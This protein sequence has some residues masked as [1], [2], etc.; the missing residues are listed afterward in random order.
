LKAIKNEL[1]ARGDSEFVENPKQIVAN[2]SG[3]TTLGFA[4]AFLSLDFYRTNGAQPNFRA[5]PIVVAAL[6]I[7]DAAL[8]VLRRLRNRASPLYGD[9][10]HFYDLLLARAWQPRRLILASVSV[11]AALGVVANAALAVREPLGVVIEILCLAAL[12]TAA[13][14]LGSLRADDAASSSCRDALRDLE[15]AA[16]RPH[17]H[18]FAHHAA[19]QAEP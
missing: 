18:N 19:R 14:R 16:K 12:A 7:L 8:A 13:V 9:R 4:I 1:D 10:R 17:S 5:F 3:S 15:S 2:D 6:P 11:S